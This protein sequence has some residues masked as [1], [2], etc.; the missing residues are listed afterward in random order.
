MINAHDAVNTAVG[1]A[2]A[3][4]EG[5]KA[6]VGTAAAAVG[7]ATGVAAGAATKAALGTRT[8]VLEAAMGAMSLLKLARAIDADDVLGLVGLMRRRR[9]PVGS[10]LLIGGGIALGAGIG[11]LLAPVSGREARAFLARNLGMI[12]G[13]VTDE[14]E[15]LQG[16]ATEVVGDVQQRAGQVVDQVQEKAGEIAGQVQEKAAAIAGQDQEGE[17]EGEGEGRRGGRRARTNPNTHLS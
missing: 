9:S 5:A 10:I 4:V 13:K 2:K 6:A 1:G 8:H 3:A 12:G 11:F 15:T 17:G 7:G 16:R 14:V